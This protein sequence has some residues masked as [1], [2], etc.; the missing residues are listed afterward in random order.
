MKNIVM[1]S[2]LE[3][4]LED[5]LEEILLINEFTVNKAKKK[6]AEETEEQQ[7]LP[8]LPYSEERARLDKSIEKLKQIER[9]MARDERDTRSRNPTINFLTETKM[10]K[11]PSRSKSARRRIFGNG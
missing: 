7:E 3:T 11:E 6:R 9:D 10:T 4:K 2:K 8:S 5:F 1:S